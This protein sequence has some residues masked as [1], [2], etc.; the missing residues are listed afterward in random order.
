MYKK[1]LVP[2]DGSALAEMVLPYVQALAECMG[3]EVVLLRVT[4]SPVVEYAFTNPMTTQSVMQAEEEETRD[5]LREKEAGLEQAGLKVSTLAGDG[6][7]GYSILET[8]NEIKADLIAMSTH[9]RSGF[10]RLM[11]GSVADQVVRGSPVPVLLIRPRN[12]K[13]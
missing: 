2:L 9:G 11:L 7:V 4:P 13:E 1:I 10:V 6:P 5:Y 12:V 3:S 8:A